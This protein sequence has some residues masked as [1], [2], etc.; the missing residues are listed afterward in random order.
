MKTR[1]MSVEKLLDHHR[2]RTFDMYSSMLEVHAVLSDMDRGCYK[3]KV[4]CRIDGAC[5]LIGKTHMH[6]L[7]S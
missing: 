5:D 3:A 6:R 7:Q 4:L 2:L 1:P